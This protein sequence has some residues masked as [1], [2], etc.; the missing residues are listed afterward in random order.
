MSSN[1]NKVWNRYAPYS[2]TMQAKC[3]TGFLAVH[4]FVFVG[5]N[6]WMPAMWLEFAKEPLEFEDLV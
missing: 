6:G 5:E 1:H 4:N 2:P 3:L